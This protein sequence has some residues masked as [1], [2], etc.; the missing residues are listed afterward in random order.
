M[1]LFE[2]LQRRRGSRACLI[3]HG[4]ADDVAVPEESPT[5]REITP[6][7]AAAALAAPT[8]FLGMI[9]QQPIIHDP[10]INPNIKRYKSVRDLEKVVQPGDVLVTGKP[11]FSLWKMFSEPISGSP[12]YHAEGVGFPRRGQATHIGVEAFNSPRWSEHSVKNL[13]SQGTRL[14]NMARGYYP[15]FVVMRPKGLQASEAKEVVREMITRS[16]RKYDLDT[17]IGG[18]LHDIFVPKTKLTQK[19]RPETVC[20]GNVC[21]TLPAMSLK[22]KANIDVVP[23]T[24]ASLALPADYLRSHNF[25]PVGAVGEFK[26]PTVFARKIRPLLARGA[27]G[28]GAAGLAYEATEHPDITAGAAGYGL[29]NALMNKLAPIHS[30]GPGTAEFAHSDIPAHLLTGGHLTSD[31]QKALLEFGGKR[32]V[33]NLIAGAGAYALAKHLMGKKENTP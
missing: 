31:G 29:S 33:P 16:K 8:P 3:K 6:S 23:G 9:G 20:E 13:E 26:P 32:L 5:H 21:S 27:L 14:R 1:S 25:E 2:T 30:L 15:D 4:L 12:L 24:P 19:I 28:L 7:M 17:A 10:A 11:D 18:W 22:S